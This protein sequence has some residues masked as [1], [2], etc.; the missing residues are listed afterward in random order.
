ML[1]RR[2]Q[3][4]QSVL[5]CFGNNCFSNKEREK[6]ENR[7]LTSCKK[8][9]KNFKHILVWLYH[10][11]DA[12]IEGQSSVIICSKKNSSSLIQVQILCLYL[13]FYLSTTEYLFHSKSK[14]GFID[15]RHCSLN[16]PGQKLSELHTKR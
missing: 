11:T 16:K 8:D 2:F 13:S 3:H 12:K 6:L 7:V 10:L 1:A 5:W 15:C 9:G 14:C 4:S